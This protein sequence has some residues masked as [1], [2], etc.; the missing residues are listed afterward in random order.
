[1]III[2]N[3]SKILENGSISLIR[4]G[5]VLQYFYA[6][7]CER[8]QSK[9]GIDLQP[10]VVGSGIHIVHGKV[11]IN[12]FSKIG[13]NCKILSDV[14]IGVSGKKGQKGAP[15]IENSVFIGTGA[16]IIGKVVI[17]DN[18]VIGANAVVTKSILESGIT[19][20]GIPA[21]KISDTGSEEYL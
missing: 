3:I 13:C 17:A 9:C 11:V 16:K 19:V 7:R 12:A 8:I 21:K 18:V 15:I 14:T 10:N 4:G 5:G 6:W 20:A 1:M 2:M